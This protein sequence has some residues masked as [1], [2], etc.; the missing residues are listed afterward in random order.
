MAAAQ[1]PASMSSYLVTREGLALG[2]F[3]I[4]SIEKG[5][6][7]GFF[8]LSDL[9][10][11]EASGWRGLFE[12]VGFA[13]A[14]AFPAGA[15]LMK[16]AGLHANDLHACD[17]A[18]PSPCEWVS[19]IVMSALTGTRPWVRLISFMMGIGCA[20][21]LAACFTLA[22]EGARTSGHALFRK[23]THPLMLAAIC[24]LSTA[25]ILYPALKLTHYAAHIAWLAKSKSPAALAAALAEQRRFWKFCGI[26]MIIHASL[27]LLLFIGSFFVARVH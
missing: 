18:G 1:S 6:K 19:P 23:D 9:G 26:L 4:S 21:L 25:L 13:K 12:I 5:L 8:R 3:K 7:T 15:S 24:A 17:A 22:A 2:T 10:W 11:H 20:L 16:S 14:S 27:T